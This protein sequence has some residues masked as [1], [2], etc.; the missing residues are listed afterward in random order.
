MMRRRRRDIEIYLDH[1]RRKLQ[2]FISKR[3][4]FS[5]IITDLQTELRDGRVKDD[6]NP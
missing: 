2:S 1:L 3:L 6:E 4:E 5:P